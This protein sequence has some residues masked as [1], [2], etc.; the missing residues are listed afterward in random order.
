V[1]AGEA[2]YAAAALAAGRVQVVFASGDGASSRSLALEGGALYAFYI[3]GSGT[4]GVVFSIAEANADGADHMHAR[5]DA[6]GALTIAWDAGQQDGHQYNGKGYGH[7]HHKGKGYGHDHDGGSGA[8]LRATGFRAAMPTTYTYDADAFDIDGDTLTYRLVEGPEGATIDAATGTVSW[9]PQASGEYRFVIRVEDGQGGS[10]EQAYDLDVTR[11]ER[12]LEVRGTDCNDQIEVVE[13]EGGIVRVTINGAT[14]YYSGI[15]GIRVEALG[16]NDQVRLKGLTASTLV[17]GGD[18]NDRIDGSL[19]VV[20]QLELHGG[21]GNDNLLGGANDD[22]LVGG[23]GNDVLRGG[24]GNDWIVGGLGK[25]VLCGNDGDDVL[26]GGKD[27]NLHGGAGN[28]WI[29]GGL[30]KDVLFGDDGDDVLVG[31]KDD[32]LHGGAGNSRTVDYAA[33]LA[34][35]VPGLP[36]RPASMLEWNWA[37]PAGTANGPGRG[38]CS[39]DWGGKCSVWGL[40]DSWRRTVGIAEFTEWSAAKEPQRKAGA[41]GRADL[42]WGMTG[43][44]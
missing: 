29:V 25:D 28:D 1:A 23:D 32:N 37:D 14:R 7:E 38:A 13:D 9:T 36:P 39:V 27:D 31:G 35:T 5:L 15:T 20:A 26:V 34:G 3:R 8:V 40:P 12:L 21:R 11:R 19:V 16:G 43:W 44:K 17:E 22:Y 41:D 42:K 24:A 18:G 33:F 2:G 10:A 6:G 30:G 4:Q